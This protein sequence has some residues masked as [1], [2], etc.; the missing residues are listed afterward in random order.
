MLTT[1]QQQQLKTQL[2]EKMSQLC[3]TFLQF[4][5][6]LTV[7]GLLGITLDQREIIL[8]NINETLTP[9][10][11][12]VSGTVDANFSQLEASESDP[13][14]YVTLPVE[15]TRQPKQKRH[16]KQSLDSMQPTTAHVHPPSSRSAA[17]RKRNRSESHSCSSLAQCLNTSFQTTEDVAEYREILHDREERYCA[18]VKQESAESVMHSC[19]VGTDTMEM[20]C[21]QDDSTAITEIYLSTKCCRQ[22]A[23]AAADDDDDELSKRSEHQSTINPGNSSSMADNTSQL[24]I[25]N[26]FSMKQ[27]QP[28]SSDGVSKSS[29]GDPTFEPA[30]SYDDDV[31]SGFNLPSE[32]SDTAVLE[33][34]LNPLQVIFHLFV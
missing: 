3:K 6:E 23:A 15:N 5:S 26:V 32:T 34:E 9:T 21:Q 4:E 10:V 2:I 19:D 18:V 11:A 20:Q 25:S 7:E 13:T 16:G 31:L 28:M 8:V 14:K 27:E 33:D 22:S 29:C 12:A 1:D 24:V 30:L 17:K